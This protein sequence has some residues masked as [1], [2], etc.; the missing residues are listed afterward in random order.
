MNNKKEAYSIKIIII[1]LILFSCFMGCN[2]QN[3][4]SKT[5]QEISKEDKQ[6]LSWSEG[7]GW[8]YDSK[9][10]EM[11]SKNIKVSTIRSINAVDFGFPYNKK[12]NRGNLTIRKHPRYGTDIIFTI[13]KGQILCRFNGCSI[14]VRFNDEKPEIFSAHGSQD[15]SSNIIFIS[16]SKKF[17][18]KIEKAKTVKIS[19][20]FFKEGNHIFEFNTENYDKE[21]IK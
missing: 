15:H 2:S 11:T 8:M 13:D 18:E 4:S 10:D 21:Y 14:P 20:P 19:V 12:D 17:I 9:I 5:K 7:N 6:L 3:N 16:S 1:L